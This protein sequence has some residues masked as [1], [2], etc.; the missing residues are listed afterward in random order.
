MKLALIPPNWMRSQMALTDLHLI[1]PWQVEAEEDRDFI[2]R[3]PGYKI[4]DNGAAE[5]RL[6][7]LN[8]LRNLAST[9]LFDEVVAP[10]ELRNAQA[11]VEG[12]RMMGHHD[13]GNLGIMAVAQGQTLSAVMQCIAAYTAMD[14]ITC[15]GIPRVLNMQFGMAARLNLI[16]ALGHD[17]DFNKKPVH[18]LGAYYPW[19]EEIKHL[20]QLPLVRSM[21]SSVPYV[22]GMHGLSFDHTPFEGMKR[23]E[24]YFEYELISSQFK[25]CQE[26]AER[27]IKWSQ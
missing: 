26:N 9:G 20:K 2:R 18:C 23:H 6:A 24:R 12:A 19:P 7:P 22:Y 8:R 1:L 25:Q 27:Y 17:A 15:I 11:A 14:H 5:G 10:D 3:L 13:W 16:E 21:D 4:L